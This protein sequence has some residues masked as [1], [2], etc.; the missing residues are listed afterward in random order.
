[1]IMTDLVRPSGIRVTNEDALHDSLL[2]TCDSWKVQGPL[3]PVCDWCG[4]QS[5]IGDIRFATERGGN[6]CLRC[7]ETETNAPVDGKP[8]VIKELSR[9]LIPSKDILRY[10]LAGKATFTVVSVETGKRFTFKVKKTPGK[11][12]VQ[13]RKSDIQ[14]PPFYF[15]G[16]MTGPDNELSY[17]YMGVINDKGA[18]HTTAKSKLREGSQQFK[19]FEFLYKW[20]LVK[21]E[22]TPKIEFWHSGRCGR[23]GKMLTVPSSIALGIGPECAKKM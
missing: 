20:L 9:R 16:A 21:P 18:F 11:K 3:T 2:A 12:I 13:Y 6:I 14:K 7:Y 15:V 5:K 1:M 4:D 8:E 19:V 17:S 23:C 10:M 22:L